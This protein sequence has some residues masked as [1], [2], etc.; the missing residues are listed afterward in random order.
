MSGV[1]IGIMLVAVMVVVVVIVIV[2]G[3][4]FITFIIMTLLSISPCDY[5]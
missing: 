1:I 5:A 2:C 3:M 4:A